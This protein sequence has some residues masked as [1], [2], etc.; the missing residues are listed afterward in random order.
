MT[1]LAIIMSPHRGQ[2]RAS[3]PLELE[4]QMIVSCCVGAKNQTQVLY[5]NSKCS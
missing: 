5:R 4:L 3:G 2:K 1:V